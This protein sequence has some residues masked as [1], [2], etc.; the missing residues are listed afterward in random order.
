MPKSAQ[1]TA[2]GSE[3]RATDRALRLWDDMRQHE[4]L[5]RLGDISA[6]AQGGDWANLLLVRLDQFLANSV[7]IACGA[8]A[9]AALEL[10][11]LGDTLLRTLPTSI[12]DTICAAIR[13]VMEKQQPE[14]VEGS[15]TRADGTV[16]RFRSI[17]LPVTD[18]A[19]RPDYV[20]CAFSSDLRA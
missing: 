11:Q 3:R 15:Y 16:V 5:P 8:A 1:K 19:A 20:M 14:R 9:R 12:A 6:Q 13:T 10:S 7:V 17:F 4:P 2:K 18:A